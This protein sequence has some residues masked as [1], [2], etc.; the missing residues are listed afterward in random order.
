M[1]LKENIEVKKPKYKATELASEL[2]GMQK[3]GIMLSL[4]K[5]VAERWYKKHET[6]TTRPNEKYQ[7]APSIVDEQIW[8]NYSTWLSCSW[9][10]YTIR[11]DCVDRL[12]NKFECE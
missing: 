8:Y 11:Y 5:M 1:T 7:F 6:A 3:S 12:P 2:N 10:F 9:Y 4:I